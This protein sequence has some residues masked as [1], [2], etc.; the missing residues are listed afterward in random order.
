[1]ALV[2][3]PGPQLDVLRRRRIHAFTEPKRRRVVLLRVINRLERL[4]PDAFHVPQVKKLVRGDRN[5]WAQVLLK[6]ADRQ[7]DSRA[8]SVFHA[9]VR[10]I[11]SVVDEKVIL[12]WTVVHPL[13]S[14]GN[15]TLDL[16]D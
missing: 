7:V 3:K 1:M 15:H 13:G 8:K 16:R 9:S 11:R 4:R 10:R 5:E 14:A 2:E 12:E 6:V